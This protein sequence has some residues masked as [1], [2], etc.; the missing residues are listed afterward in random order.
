MVFQD[1]LSALTPV[2]TVGDQIA[3]AIRV[4]QTV[5]SSRPPARAVEL[6]ELVGI[7]NAGAARQRASR[8]SSPAACASASMIAMAIANDPDLI[9]CRRADHRAGR[10]RPG[11]DPRGAADRAARSP[12][13]ASCMITHDLGVVAGFADRVAGDVRRPAGGDR[14]RRRRLLPRRGCPTRM[15]LLR[16]G[17]ARWTRPGGS[18]WCPIEGDPPSLAA[19]PP[20]CP[21]APRCPLASTPAATA[22]PALGRRSAPASHRAA[23]HP[24]RRRS[25]AARPRGRPTSYRRRP[26]R[27]AGGRRASARRQRESSCGSTD[28][29]KH[30]PL[31]K[32]AVFKR[33]IGTVQRRRRRS[34]ST[35]A[36]ARRSASSA[37]PAAARRRR[38]MEILELAAPQAGTIDVLGQRRRDAG[39]GA[40]GGRCAA[41]CR[42]SSR[43]RWPRWTRGCRSATSWPS[44]CA[45]TASARATAAAGRRAARAGRPG[46]RARRPLPAGVLRRPAPAHRHRPRAGAASPKLLVLDEPVSAL[47]V[48]IQAGVINLLE[49]LQAELGLSY[50]FVA[51]DLSVVRHIADRVAVMYLGRIVEIGAGRT[52]VFDAPDA[53][54]H[55]GPAVR[56]PDA[57]PAQGARQRDGSCSRATCPA[58]PTRRR[59][60]A[61]A[62]AARSSRPRWPST[63]RQRCVDEEPPVAACAARTT[64]PPATTPEA[65]EVV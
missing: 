1:P 65:R 58:R 3:E 12:A 34:A 63:T 4:H 56:D 42:S 40:T 46:A 20:G 19:L 7:P 47:D 13:P 15:G 38:C 60:A 35:S 41:T 49:E 9:I 55:A 61:S 62:P 18:R 50:L 53:P 33:R 57:R 6:L 32:G 48:S 5:T 52:T 16:L 23:L 8:T 24:Q 44:R 31:T 29:V 14:R 28:L 45:R 10:H 59:A 26:R 30:Y 54:L 27:R 22:E 64:A 2:Y 21:F 36:R 51:H 37:S 17:A 39:R 43:T 11:A 25:T